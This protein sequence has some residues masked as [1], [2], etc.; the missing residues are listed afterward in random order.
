MCISFNRTYS[1]TS[2]YIAKGSLSSAGNEVQQKGKSLHNTAIDHISQS[3]PVTLHCLSLISQA[4]SC[5][6]FSQ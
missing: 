6:C 1:A 4:I 5:E 3:T 2:K